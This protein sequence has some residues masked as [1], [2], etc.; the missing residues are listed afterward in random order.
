MGIDHVFVNESCHSFWPHY[1][2]N[3]EVYNNRNFEEIQNLSEITHK[4]VL[5]HT[6]EILIVKTIESTFP[7]WTRST[8]SHDQLTQWTSK[9]TWL[10]RF[11]P[12]LG[13]RCRFTK[14]QF[15]DGKVIWKNSKCPLLVE[16]YSELME[17]Q[18][19]SSG[20][21]SQVVRHCRFFKKSRMICRKGR[22]ILNNSQ[23]GSSSCQCSTILIGQEKDT[24][25]F[26]LRIQKE[27][28]R[29]RR[30]SQEHWTVLIPGDEKEYRGKIKVPSW[31][32]LRRWY[33]DSRK[34]VS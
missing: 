32:K 13:W 20:I 10:L 31:R 2:D 17:K 15:Q 30:N 21:S 28:R 18:L 19:N 33:S 5:E 23:I 8:L 14:K 7:S 4:L 22:V 27:S 16:N 25:I 11:C 26:L 29:T 6:E 12:M 9:S 3:V 34:Q 24:M 1:T